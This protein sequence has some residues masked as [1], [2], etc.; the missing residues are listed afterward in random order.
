MKWVEDLAFERYTLYAGD[1]NLWLHIW[2]RECPTR[3]IS[4]LK[5]I[6][7]LNHPT[8]HAQATSK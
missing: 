5:R 1:A 7:A 3:Q 4:E 2:L 8:A 6:V